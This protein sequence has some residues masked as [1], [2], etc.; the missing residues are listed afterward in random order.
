MRP[1][2]I[3]TGWQPLPAGVA[4]PEGEELIAIGD[5]HGEADAFDVLLERLACEPPRGKRQL[6]LL[7]DLIDR[8]PENLRTMALADEAGE[9]LGAELTLCLGNH[10]GMLL[11]ALADPAEH[12]LLWWLNGGDAVLDEIDPAGRIH[13]DHPEARRLLAEALPQGFRTLLERGVSHF[14]WDDL[15]LVHA[16]LHP[17]ID[18]AAFLALPPAATTDD[19]WAWV[20]EPFLEYTG[21]WQGRIIV[22]G[23]SVHLDR[24]EIEHADQVRDALDLTATHH[25][26]CLDVGAGRYRRVAALQVR[27]GLY[28][29]I[30]VQA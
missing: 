29:I 15:L 4:T 28:R 22:H 10:E 21:G 8:G 5:V 23:H 20:R 7:G 27:D 18:E 25:R 30:L 2:E 14:R 3:T 19:H 16:G 26:I 1:R 24:R 12:L 6:V 11:D 13:P 17:G 9:R